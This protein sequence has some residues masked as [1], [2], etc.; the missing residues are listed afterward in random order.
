MDDRKR[1]GVERVHTRGKCL[2]M[3]NGII[4]GVFKANGKRVRTSTDHWK[5]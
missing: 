5:V 1:G 2:I 4:I 3:G